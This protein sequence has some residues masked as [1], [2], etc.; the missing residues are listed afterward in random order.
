ML[1]AIPYDDRRPGTFAFVHLLRLLVSKAKAFQFKDNDALD[2]CHAVLGAAY[3]SLATLDK[4]WKGRI[5][6]LP[7][8]NRLAKM[9]YRPELPE[10]VSLLESLVA[11]RAAS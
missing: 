9:F 10:L 11:E 7:R 5:E 1:A 4:Q 2:F 8:P 6:R 3:G